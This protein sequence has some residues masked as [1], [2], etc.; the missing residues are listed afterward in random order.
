[1]YWVACLKVCQLIEL[2]GMRLHNLNKHGI[3]LNTLLAVAPK[4]NDMARSDDTMAHQV[5]PSRVDKNNLVF[6]SHQ[7][8]TR[9]E[10]GSMPAAIRFSLKA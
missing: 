2:G 3:A 5:I 6:W 9:E 1:M 10:L 8:K 4:L 7:G